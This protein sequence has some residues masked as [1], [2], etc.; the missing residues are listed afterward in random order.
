MCSFGLGVARRS[1]RGRRSLRQCSCRRC[2]IDDMRHRLCHEGLGKTKHT[3][4]EIMVQIVKAQVM[5]EKIKQSREFC[6][7]A[8]AEGS[9]SF[10]LTIN[11]CFDEFRYLSMFFF[12]AIDRMAPSGDMEIRPRL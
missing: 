3:S 5:K 6:R 12:K 10:F 8:A 2:S 9:M 11:L 7:G 1:Q 4:K